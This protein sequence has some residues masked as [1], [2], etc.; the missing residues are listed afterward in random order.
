MSSTR[1]TTTIT[2]DGKRVKKVKKRRTPTSS[3]KVVQHGTGTIIDE[4]DVVMGNWEDDTT[5]SQLGMLAMKASSKRESDIVDALGMANQDYDEE[6]PMIVA[7][8]T[9]KIPTKHLLGRETAGLQTA[10]QLRE[11]SEAFQTAK[12]KHL[13][14]LDPDAIGRGKETVYRDQSGRRIDIA[15]QRAELA[16]K[17]RA[18]EAQLEKEMEWGKGRVQRQAAELRKQYEEQEAKKPMARYADDEDLNSE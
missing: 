16:A 13:E 4:D 12:R 3:D 11:S 5:S 17:K 2:I 8:D 10:Q 6:A 14:Q 1:E 18:E 7:V 15:A 9:S